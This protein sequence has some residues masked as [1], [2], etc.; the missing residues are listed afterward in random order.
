METEKNIISSEAKLSAIASVMFFSPFIKNDIKSEEFSE[1]E[2]SFIYG[3]TQIW[4]INLVFLA[5]TLLAALANVFEANLILTRIINLW[6]FA[7]YI[8]SVFSIFAC[9]NDLGMWWPNESI[10][11]D[12]QH[13]WQILKVYA[14]IMNFIFWFRQENYNMPYRWLKESV[15]LR[16]IFIFGT[17]LFWN[18]FGI[19]ILAII[20]IRIIL[21]M[22]NIDIIPLSI[23]KAINSSFSCNPGEIF[24]YIFAPLVSMIK[25]VDYDTV[26]QAKKQWYAQWQIFGMWI[27]L[28]YALFIGMLF[29]LY[30][31][32]D[33]SLYDIIL[34]VAVVLW[35][36]RII[37]FYKEKSTF[38][39]IPILS[40]ITSLIFN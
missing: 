25:K 23:K 21:L 40:E 15:L 35:I 13:K 18:W 3:Y 24:A 31:G 30:R 28:Q 9:V 7:I 1:D 8:I 10:N 38:L 29:I 17:L 22:V 12:I 26:L 16:T 19:G 6:S 11:Q 36:V 20:I 33:I 4:L 34:L 39:R 5:I 2:R 32:I 14:P 27:I 37:I